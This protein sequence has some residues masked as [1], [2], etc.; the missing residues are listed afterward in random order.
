MVPLNT[1]A[2]INLTIGMGGNRDPLTASQ[3]ILS[4][5]ISLH[6]ADALYLNDWLG[7]AVVD[8]IPDDAVRQWREVSGLEGDALVT[9]QEAE[10]EFQVSQIVA[11]A[12]KWARLY[13][14]AGIIMGIDGTGQMHEPLDVERV[15]PGALKWLSLIDRWHLIPMQVNFVNPL[16]ADWGRPEIYTAYGGN[17]PVHRSRILFFYGTALPYHLAIRSHFW[18][19][20]VLERV[21]ESIEHAGIAQNGIAKL[22]TEAKVDVF[23]L[24]DLFDRLRTKEGTQQVMERLRLGNM[25]KSLWNALLMDTK[26]DYEQKTGALSQGLAGLLSQF[27]QVVAAA[28]GIPVTRLLGTSTPGMNA[29]GEEDTRKYYDRVR[30]IQCNDIEPVLKVLDQVMLRSVL[31][32]APEDFQSEFQSLW[33]QSDTERAATQLQDAQRDQA[34]LDM[35]IVLEHH[36]ADRVIEEGIYPTLRAEDS[37]ALEAVESEYGEGADDDLGALGAFGGFGGADPTGGDPAEA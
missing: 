20:S 1:D 33:Q 37:T 21:K 5:R 4:D 13:G 30:A 17:D 24:P 26:E 10:K 34:Y 3:H 7:A 19:A 18:G 36:I 8:T 23:K 16:R 15:R 32:N 22:I 27:L 12:M 11:Q 35:G 2:L 25:S 29:T 9:F 28:S 31:G 14:G 6:E